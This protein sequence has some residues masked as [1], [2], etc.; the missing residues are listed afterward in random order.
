M[1]WTNKHKRSQKCFIVVLC[2]VLLIDLEA[3]NNIINAI[4]AVMW[5]NAFGVYIF[6]SFI[7][8]AFNNLSTFLLQVGIFTG[9]W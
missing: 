9:K 5:C 2:C 6:L 8:L 1:F 4:Y 7:N 3:D